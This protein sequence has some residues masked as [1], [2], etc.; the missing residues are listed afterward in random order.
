MYSYFPL[1]SFNNMRKSSLEGLLQGANIVRRNLNHI[2]K[3][4]HVTHKG[5]C[6]VL[7]P[8]DFSR[9]VFLRKIQWKAVKTLIL[10]VTL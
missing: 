8:M 10:V 2:S 3:D 1:V 7:L 6:L 4:P 9:T 5:F